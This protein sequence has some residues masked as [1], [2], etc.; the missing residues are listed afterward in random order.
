[1]P[2][3]FLLLG[4]GLTLLFGT[5]T[6]REQ[7][8]HFWGWALGVP[9]LGW[10]G[11][12]FGRVW[13]H[14]RQHAAADGWDE[15]RE[16][17]LCRKMGRG[18]RSQQVL[19]VSLYTAL[20]EAGAQPAAQLDAL[21]EGAEVLKGQ[22]G[23][24][25]GKPLLHSR[26]ASDLASPED[27]LLE[28][29]PQ[30]LVD[31]RST[32]APLPDDA[33]VALLLEVDSGL[34]ENQL[35]HVWQQA[36]ALAGIRQSTVPVA[37]C[38][39]AAVDQWLDQRINDQALLM[40]VAVQFAPQEPKGTAEVVVGMLFG[41]RLTQ[42]TLAPLAYLHRPEQECEAGNEALRYAARQALDWVPLDATQIKQVWRAGI[43]VQREA[44]LSTLLKDLSL[45]AALDSGFCDLDGALG[46]A[47][48]A[49]PWL[50][51]AV[52]TQSLQRGAGPQF[53]FSGGGAVEAG[54]WSTVLTPVPPPSK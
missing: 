8:V 36:W 42:T 7:P 16:E 33:P 26:L 34:P 28:V 21:L 22:P 18:R 4:V 40:V 24:L 27:A 44:A 29:L 6:L 48:Q 12:G 1:M 11:L 30:V 53:I 23:W 32:L 47:G 37:G 41:N 14:I 46:H 9:L 35:R 52:A 15:A 10:F 19:S 54:L 45:P 49:S 20:R 25:G 17:D 50:A 31:L 13:G 5:Q 2:L 43:A 38:G 51:I 3:C 39:L